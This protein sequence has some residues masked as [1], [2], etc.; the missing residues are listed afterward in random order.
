MGQN[1]FKIFGGAFG[2]FLKAT[3]ALFG[4]EKPGNIEPASSEP[5]TSEVSAGMVHETRNP[6]LNP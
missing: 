5:V 6:N 4:S 3:L 2:W 1:N